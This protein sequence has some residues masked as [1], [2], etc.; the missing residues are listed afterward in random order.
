MSIITLIASGEKCGHSE[1][2]NDEGTPVGWLDDHSRE[3]LIQQGVKET[4]I[5]K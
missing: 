4:I 3:V 5:L 1:L 2:L